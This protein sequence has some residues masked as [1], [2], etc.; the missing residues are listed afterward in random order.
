MMNMRIGLFPGTFNPLHNGHLQTALETYEAFRLD[1]LRF[2]PT[3]SPPH[4]GSD[5]LFASALRVKMLTESIEGFPQ[6]SVSDKE[7]TE[8]EKPRY[9]I[10]TLKS[11]TKEEPHNSFFL[12]IGEDAFLDLHKWKEGK[13]FLSYTSLIVNLRPG[14]QRERIIQQAASLFDGGGTLCTVIPADIPRNETLPLVMQGTNTLFL[15]HVTQL[16]ISSSM[17]RKRLKQKKKIDF[18]VPPAVVGLLS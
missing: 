1:T 14:Y 9:T 18:L 3:A 10:D 12:I 16:D 11:F 8:E 4:K 15:H 17:I 7:I 6:F 13:N 2:I 5:N